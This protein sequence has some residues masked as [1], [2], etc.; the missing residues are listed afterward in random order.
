MKDR[1]K[2]AFWILFTVFILMTSFLVYTIT[3]MG[4]TIAN[5][6]EGYGNT[7]E[8][9]EQI[10]SALKGKLS[11]KDFSIM[12]SGDSTTIELKTVKIVFGPDAKVKEVV[13]LSH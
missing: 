4:I 5:L 10:S 12:P 8:D 13:A 9:L 7:E 1:W 6:Y 11:R 2:R 3:D